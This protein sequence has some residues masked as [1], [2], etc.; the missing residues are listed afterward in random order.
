[1]STTSPPSPLPPKLS[2]YAF[3]PGSQEQPDE[4]VQGAAATNP[5]PPPGVAV[6]TP[7]PCLL[8]PLEDYQRGK[9]R[10]RHRHLLHLTTRWDL[11]DPIRHCTRMHGPIE[12]LRS[13]SAASRPSPRGFGAETRLAPHPHPPHPTPSVRSRGPSPAPACHSRRQRNAAGM[14]TQAGTRCRG[15]Y[16]HQGLHRHCYLHCHY[17]SQL[18]LCPIQC[19]LHAL[20]LVIPMTPSHPQAVEGPGSPHAT[21]PR[22]SYAL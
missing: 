13:P 19:H 6:S 21:S 17:Q 9:N 20:F 11:C 1:M 3:S 16:R 15:R 22:V 14:D 18:N 5:F 10:H 2:E 8:V 12:L 4:A 7:D